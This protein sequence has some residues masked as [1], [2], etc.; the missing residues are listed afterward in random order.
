MDTL[1]QSSGV[2]I[3]NRF[4]DHNKDY[5]LKYATDWT[6][7]P[8]DKFSANRLTIKH[9]YVNVSVEFWKYDGELT[10][11]TPHDDCLWSF[12]DKGTMPNRTSESIVPPALRWLFKYHL[13]QAVPS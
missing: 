10:E 8:G 3:N 7:I 12:V 1:N 5:S 4:I 9:E 2:V 13:C 11:P 6:L